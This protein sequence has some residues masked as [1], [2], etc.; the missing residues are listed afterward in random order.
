MVRA[1]AKGGR[2]VVVDPADRPKV[3]EYLQKDKPN[4]WFVNNLAAK[5]EF[6]VSKY[7]MY[8]VKFRSN[9][10]FQADLWEQQGEYGG[11][12][13]D[14]TEG[15]TFSPSIEVIGLMKAPKSGL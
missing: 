6:I 7:C 10:K 15:F 8:S 12:Y 1:A 13:Y 5:A 2:I 3:I 9:D 14:Y 11:T 4:N